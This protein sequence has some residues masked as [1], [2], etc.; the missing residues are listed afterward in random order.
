MTFYLLGV[1]FSL[2]A[3]RLHK[4]AA[5]TAIQATKLFFDSIREAVGD[6]KFSKF[7]S[8]EAERTLSFAI[9][10]TGSM[11]GKKCSNCEIS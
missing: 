7:L 6:K 11:G 3:N 5:S 1:F 8:M 10:T 4:Q 2:C 9:D